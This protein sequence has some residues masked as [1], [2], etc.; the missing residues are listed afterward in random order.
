MIAER[1]TVEPVELPV[2]TLTVTQKELDLLTALVNECSSAS[3]GIDV[4]QLF[5]ALSGA[6]GNT[7]GVDLT[8]TGTY[9]YEAA[10]TVNEV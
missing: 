2:A 8:K 5:N 3:K 1:I 6:G 10:F 7:D 9:S 4:M